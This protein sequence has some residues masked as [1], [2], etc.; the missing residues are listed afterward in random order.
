LIKT[1]VEPAGTNCQYGGIK[2]EVGLDSNRNGILNSNEINTSSTNYICNVNTGSGNGSGSGLA[3]SNM[4]VYDSNGTFTVP[5]GV[6]KIMVEGW[7]G[8]RG[9]LSGGVGVGGSY[10]K[11]IL[12]V[13]SGNSY[14]INIGSAGINGQIANV[15]GGNSTFGNIFLIPGGGSITQP[16][17]VQFYIQSISKSVGVFGTNSSQTDWGIGGDAPCGGQG[18]SYY[19]NATAPGGGAGRGGGNAANGRIVVYW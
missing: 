8:G 10:G 7:G 11:A 4:Q 1:T 18:G 13:I 2:I 14:S 6:T 19:Q 9:A 5:T 17:G 16:I 15:A 3:Y 12:S